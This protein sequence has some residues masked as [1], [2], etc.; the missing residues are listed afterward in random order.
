M[1]VI[2]SKIRSLRDIADDCFRNLC[3]SIHGDYEPVLSALRWKVYGKDISNACRKWL[4]L[5]EFF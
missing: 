5:G 4:H 1:P 3:T 2:I